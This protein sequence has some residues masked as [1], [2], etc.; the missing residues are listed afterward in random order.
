MVF[1][2]L[3]AAPP[4]SCKDAAHANVNFILR[5]VFIL[6]FDTRELIYTT[7]LGLGA[8]ENLASLI[9]QDGILNIFTR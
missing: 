1:R 9:F 4:I 5:D 7:C 2:G 6:F 3:A 8:H